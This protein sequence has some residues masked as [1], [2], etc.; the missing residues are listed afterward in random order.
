MT[1]S[2]TFATSARLPLP[3]TTLVGRDEEIARVAALLATPNVRLVTLTGPGGVGKT[4][5]ALHAL[6]RL[7]GRFPHGAAL[8][9]LAPVRDPDLVLRTIARTLGIREQA[10]QSDFDALARSLR[11]HTQLLCLDNLEHV[12]EVAPLLGELLVICPGLKLL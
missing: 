12:V 9:G 3:L 10:G 1:A 11:D 5:L 8:V 4:R 6:A 2:G 7:E